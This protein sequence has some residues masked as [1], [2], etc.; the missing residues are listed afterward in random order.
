MPLTT[1]EV[2]VLFYY[3]GMGLPLLAI[4]EILR[5]KLHLHTPSTSNLSVRVTEVCTKEQQ[6]GY[7]AL[8]RSSGEWNRPALDDFLKRIASGL[9]EDAQSYLTHIGDAEQEIIDRVCMRNTVHG[10]SVA[11]E[12]IKY[13][14]MPKISKRPRPRKHDASQNGPGHEQ[15]SKALVVPPANTTGFTPVSQH[16]PHERTHATDTHS[17]KRSRDETS[18]PGSHHYQITS[19]SSTASNFQSPYGPSGNNDSRL[20]GSQLAYNSATFRGG[21]TNTG[22]SFQSPDYP[23]GAPPPYSPD[24]PY[25]ASPPYSDYH[26][27]QKDRRAK[28]RSTG[29]PETSGYSSITPRPKGPRDPGGRDDIYL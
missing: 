4:Q 22:P 19:D 7:P 15:S 10:C 18:H 16:Q 21:H 1:A 25:G 29:P 27:E 13:T 3:R 17:R 12:S 6:D 9:S 11:N 26:P 5:V 23:Y 28:G 14:G 20:I 8:R 24:Y 2:F